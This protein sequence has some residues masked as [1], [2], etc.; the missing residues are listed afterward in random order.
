MIGGHHSVEPAALHDFLH[1]IE[2]TTLDVVLARVGVD[3][4][5]V[6]RRAFAIRRA[7]QPL[8]NHPEQRLGERPA[9]AV[10][11]FG[12]EHSQHPFHRLD[13]R[14]GVQRA[15]HQ[16]T[17]LGG[18]QSR[19]KRLPVADL[20][21]Q[22]HVRVLSQRGPKGVVELQGVQAHFSMPDQ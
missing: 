14:I 20:S 19:G 18:F 13:R 11:F 16:V 3:Q 10:L 22:D 9:N 4:D 17:G 15:E 6:V 8:G 21:D 7:D 1:I 12:W 5:V 2:S